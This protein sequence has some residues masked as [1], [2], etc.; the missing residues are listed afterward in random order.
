MDQADRAS[1]V[2]SIAPELANLPACQHTA[3]M[4]IN[5]LA[6]ADGIVDRVA[7][8][9]P[10][11]VELAGR[12]VPLADRHLD[13]FDALISGAAAV[14][15][16]P[17]SSCKRV[18]PADFNIHFTVGP[19]L[20]ASGTIR[21]HGERWWGGFARREIPGN[22]FSPLPFG[23]YVAAALAMSEVFK[24]VRLREYVPLESAF[25]SLWTMRAAGRPDLDPAWSGPETV[26]GVPVSATLAG[27]GAVGSTWLHAL[28]ATPGLGGAG[29]L[30]DNDKYG[31]DTTNL[32]RCPIFGRSSVGSAKASEAARICADADIV[33]TP[34]DGPIGTTAS[35]RPGL[36]VSAVDTNRS[37]RAVQGLYPPRLLSGS[38]HDL[39]AE[40]LRCDPELSTACIHCYNPVEPDG[41]SD[42]ELRKRFLTMD[43]AEQRQLAE[44]LKISIDEAVLWGTEGVCGFAGDQVAAR[45]R[46]TSGGLSAFAV[47]F[48][49]VMAGTM[50]AAL[51]VQESLRLGP[52]HD[53]TCRAVFQFFDPLSPR[54][55]PGMLARQSA[56]PMCDPETPADGIWRRRFRTY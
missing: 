16:V 33:L 56:C 11:G 35:D 10:R 21:V 18:D 14:D 15:A 1:V 45:L 49:S 29:L 40:V 46:P 43:P 24:A 26:D 42:D 19:G 41:E 32:N 25:H 53:S 3:W 20:P 22:G 27:V 4:L 31:V 13:L 39:R 54:N 51:T 7:L 28:W 34:H 17:V 44:D 55:A 50:L 2:V 9:C 6:R 12:I 52:L 48:V 36:M 30:A 38:T 8:E 5:L 37:R 47:G 23:P